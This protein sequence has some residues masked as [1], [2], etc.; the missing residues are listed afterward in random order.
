MPQTALRQTFLSNKVLNGETSYLSSLR[1]VQLQ[2]EEW[3]S[4]EVE[5]VKYQSKVEDIQTSEKVRVYHH[6]LHRKHFKNSAILELQTETET[7]KGHAACSSYLQQVVSDLLENP[8]NL[9]PVAQRELLEELD[10]VFT[11]SDNKMLLKS[12]T[13]EEVHESVK[14][15]N[16]NAAPGNDGITSLLYKECFDILGEA[17]TQ[18]RTSNQI[19]TN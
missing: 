10:T 13:L 4:V 9:D 19:T 1:H 14:T 12:P 17:L 3:F 5:K 18:W 15:S 6:E 16:S 2:I 11:E 8:V 7:L